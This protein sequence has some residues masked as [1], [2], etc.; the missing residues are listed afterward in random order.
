MERFGKSIRKVYQ[1]DSG[2]FVGEI[3]ENETEIIF[4]DTIKIVPPKVEFSD[5]SIKRYVV[6]SHDLYS[7]D[8]EPNSSTVHAVDFAYGII[9]EERLNSDEE[10]RA[11][12]EKYVFSRKGLDN[13]VK[14]YCGLLPIDVNIIDEPEEGEEKRFEGFDENINCEY[15]E[16]MPE[17]VLD[18]V[19][20]ASHRRVYVDE[21]KE[22]EIPEED[23]PKNSFEMF[24]LIH[25]AKAPKKQ[26]KSL[27][28]IWADLNKKHDEKYRSKVNETEESD[29][30][31]K[32]PPKEANL[33]TTG[34][35]LLIICYRTGDVI[36]RRPEYD[37]E[38]RRNGKI[39]ISKCTRINWCSKDLETKQLSSII[40][41]LLTVDDE[42]L[43]KDEDYINKMV[44][45]IGVPLLK[46]AN[47][48]YIGKRVPQ[49]LG[50]KWPY[51]GAFDP[52]AKGGI[53]SKDTKNQKYFARINREEKKLEEQVQNEIDENNEIETDFD[54]GIDRIE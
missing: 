34:E 46:Y 15:I 49:S 26:K 47:E 17:V 35:G 54:E 36:T 39:N 50:V 18:G 27:K 29:E 41:T 52:N 20:R 33:D 9:D 11:R 30:I 48:M 44:L 13:V 19:L 38:G 24:S 16:G 12:M 3:H 37:E 7:N 25:G 8:V 10:Y 6:I 4:Y 31:R 14:N 40:T 43:E 32:F 23:I 1:N 2:L 53:S 51:L 28:E 42:R 21:D 45:E 5:D 22:D